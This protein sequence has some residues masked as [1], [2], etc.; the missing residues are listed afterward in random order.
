MPPVG[1]SLIYT[2]IADLDVFFYFWTF[3]PLG[4]VVTRDETR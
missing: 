4:G 1:V 3:G 2:G